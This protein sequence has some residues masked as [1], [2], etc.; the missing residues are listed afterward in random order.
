LV[1]VGLEKD[2]PVIADDAPQSTNGLQPGIH[3]GM[4]ISSF[5]DYQ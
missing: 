4:D 1:G 5:Y 2:Y 3:H